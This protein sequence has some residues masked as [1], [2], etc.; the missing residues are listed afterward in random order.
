MAAVKLAR[1]R[2]GREHEWNARLETS[3]AAVLWYLWRLG[4]GQK[5][6]GRDGSARY[7]CSL[8]Q[9]VS[10]LAPVMGWQGTR[11]QLVR[12]HRKSV[13]RWLDWL[14]AAGLVSHTSQ[15]DEEGFWWRTIIELHASPELPAETLQAAVQ[16]RRGWC[17][18]ERQRDRRG[19]RRRPAGERLR[20]L[21]AILRRARLSRSQRRARAVARRRAQQ[22]HSERRAA[23]AAI[24][25]SLAS[26]TVDGE[27]KTH[28][29]HPFGVETTSRSKNQ[30]LSKDEA[31][32]S[33]FTRARA[34]SAPALPPTAS[35][36]TTSF[37]EQEGLAAADRSRPAHPG[38]DTSRP[39]DQATADDTSLTPAPP[40]SRLQLDDQ[41]WA[42][43]H[44]AITRWRDRPP[45]EWRPLVDAIEAR[46]V[47]LEEWASG[48]SWPRWRL[49]EAWTTIA[50]GVEYAA[51][52]AASR[53]AMWSP[54]HPNHG[55]RLARA[56]ERYER[57]RQHRP[58]GWPDSGISGLIHLLRSQHPEPGLQP[59]CLAY[60]VQA[61]NR[62]TKGLAAYAKTH[63]SQQWADRAQARA[64]RRAGPAL[65]AA[66]EIN[67]RLP[68]RA[69]LKP[70]GELIA[71]PYPA[72]G[73]QRKSRR[74]ADRD[75]RLLAGQVPLSAGTLRAAWAFEDRWLS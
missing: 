9:L 68:E 52:G 56:I 12:A 28:L 29:T 31:C 64:T 42:I 75:R 70:A 16:R 10:G 7:A 57:H 15:Q 27:T 5:W 1:E 8:S 19:E 65:R 58:P 50:W 30:S 54:Q 43:A 25:E 48:R 67:R 26:A 39:D 6:A 41:V 51:A 4:R 72:A 13:Q 37:Q 34:Q 73:T 74:L 35:R 2:A 47:E 69:W 45:G 63:D 44:K 49:L 62:W 3:A 18:R 11:E 22:L 17:A 23:R 71:L 55:P 24:H 59:R 20:N 66:S 46:T 60:D 21:T 33:T 61:F 53:L 36:F 40:R 14:D 38:D 32:I